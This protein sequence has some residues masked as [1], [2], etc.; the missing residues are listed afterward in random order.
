MVNIVSCGAAMVI[1]VRLNALFDVTGVL[2]S[3]NASSVEYAR[4]ARL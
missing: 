4:Y 3:R 1:C 2:G